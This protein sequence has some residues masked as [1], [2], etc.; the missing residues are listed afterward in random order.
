MAGKSPSILL[1]IFMLGATSTY[2]API[3]GV[4]PRTMFFLGTGARL[5]VKGLHREDEEGRKMDITV[6]RLLLSYSFMP[7]VVATLN[8][9]YVE[10]DM[11]GRSS[12]G[13]ADTWLVAKYRF[14]HGDFPRGS[15][16]AS[17]LWGVKLPTGSHT[18]RDAR[19]TLPGP[20]Q[21][22]TGS[23]DFIL[24]IAAGHLTYRYNIEGGLRY[25]VNTERAGVRTGNSLIYDISLQWKLHPAFPLEVSQ[26]NLGV[27]LNGVWK[28]KN[29]MGGTIITDTGGDVVLLS[30]GIQYILTERAL[31]ELSYQVPV[32]E[33]A[34]RGEFVTEEA[35]LT[36]FRYIF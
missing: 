1:I 32:V 23:W 5:F 17:L 14:F 35:L 29:R 13:V 9:G 25:R 11:A 6:K 2:G 12:E 10:K 33:N 15:T 30:P 3:E 4:T 21:P 22:G 19:G 36:G 20:L 26:L 8:T 24:G 7:D 34:R 16:M 27:E 18:E 28:E 31:V